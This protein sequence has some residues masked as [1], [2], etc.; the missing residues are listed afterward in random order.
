ML[1][2]VYNDTLTA[3]ASAASTIYGSPGNDTI[4]AGTS[5]T[6]DYSTLNIYAAAIA[7]SVSGG[8][9]TVDKTDFLG[10]DTITL[11]NTAIVGTNGNDSFTGFY[12]L[13]DLT[14][15]GLAGSDTYT[16][17]MTQFGASAGDAGVTIVEDSSGAF[18]NI[19]VSNADGSFIISIDSN[20]FYAAPGI[21]EV[22]MGYYKWNSLADY[23][24]VLDVTFEKQQ[25]SSEVQFFTIGSTN[26]E[27]GSWYNDVITGATGNHTIDG[28][29]GTN[30]ID[31]S[32]APAGITVDLATNTASNGWGYTDAL[33]NIQ[34][35]IGSSHNDTITGDSNDN[36]IS[37][38][39]GNN[40]LDGGSGT[41]TLDYSSDPAGVTVDLATGTATNGWSG[42]DTISNFQNVIGS[43][44][45]DVITG[46]SNN[47]VI[48]GG[49]GNNTLDGGGG[50]NTLDYSH[51]PAGVTVDLVTGT[52]T[53]GYGGTDTI[54]NFQNVLGSN[55]G[56]TIIGNGNNVI[57]CGSGND[58][59]VDGGGNNTFD[60]GGGI[61][62]LDYSNDPAGV[63][64]D[65]ATGT[66]TNGFG[67]TDTITN[68]QNVI[69]SA[70]GD[71]ITG[72]AN[73]NVITVG[74]GNNTLD[75]GG[76]TNTLDYSHQTAGVYVDLV[77]GW[78]TNGSGGTDTISNFQDVIGSNY[79]DTIIGDGNNVITGGSGNDHVIDGG[80]NNVFDGGGGT[81]TLD[82]S[83]DPAAVTVDLSAGTASNGFGGTDTISNFQN[84]IGSAYDDVIT[85]DSNNNVID[86]A[87]GNNTLD[88]GGGTNTLDYHNDPSSVYVD[89]PDGVVYNGYGG[90]DTITN[91]QN[92]ISSVYGDTILG[93]S[94]DNVIT[95]M[96]ANNYVDGGGGTNTID[97]SHATS[98]VTIDL[99]MYVA[100]NDGFGG[101]DDLYNIQNIIG[102]N[103]GDLITGNGNNVITCGSGD[104]YVID[105]GGNNVF[106]G[107]GGTN[108]LSYEADPAGVTVDLAT[109]TATN[110]FSGTD[111]ISNFQNVVGSYYDDVIT[112]DSHNNI[113]D[114]GGGNN[115]LD[116]GGGI[117]TLDYSHDPG[118]V[119][120]ELSSGI[121][122]N[123]YGGTDTISN[124][125]N[126]I[127]SASNDDIFGD[128]NNNVISG[129]AG[130]NTLDGGGGTNTLDYSHN[131]GSVYVDLVDGWATNGWA[132]TDTISNFQNV[133]GSNF[134]DTI[135]GNGNNVITCGSGDDYVIDGGGN[136]TF[137]GGGGTN[138]L[139]YESDP[140][141]VTVD[142]SA[143]TATNGFGGTD[144]ISNFQVVV[145]S[146][147][148]DSITGDGSTTVSYA[149]ATG[150][151]TVDLSAGTATGDGSDTLSG[152][153]GVIGSSYDDTITCDN[154]NDVIYGNGG[155]D[156]I[157]CGSGAD[158][159]L[160][161]GA[162]ALTGVDTINNFN[163]SNG[164]KIDIADVISTYDPL[165]MLISNFVELTTSGSNTQVKVDTDGSGSSYTQIATIEGV[166]GLSLATLIS[167]GNLIVHHT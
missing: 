58:H 85:G 30:T 46:D 126:V 29:P 7:V 41:N 63:T 10:E 24:N 118:S 158:T 164:D 60:G 119:I 88:G 62:T 59:V 84:V 108:T 56:D 82:Y 113:I 96:G 43:A 55:Y 53:N 144:T 31:Y 79:G 17:D 48:D 4:T 28:G 140:A 160:F 78:A 91:F 132:G 80:G 137:N 5:T 16:F 155:N 12:V 116:G 154:N 61:N 106:D 167:D 142:L 150:A 159:I 111:T 37:G 47:N 64:V 86:G 35:V 75:G 139:S 153:T 27:F 114:G 66:A 157:Y 127:G 104:D 70:Y 98:G 136:N 120:V 151:V 11:S 26:Y 110:G 39:A 83:N 165:S 163:T 33:Y 49:A 92:I 93:D 124:F 68:F 152:I 102:S 105:G 8:V 103:F 18:S 52:A 156:A 115:T 131:P 100:T 138:T 166:T 135:I 162:T 128:L 44:H 77:D 69:G 32:A 123:G 36:L 121:A 129:G 122:Y 65:L 51:D 141:G 1:G 45:D 20:I 95:I 76:G 148:D 107:G 3:L 42:T 22:E 112:G 73:D 87:G 40:T 25:L 130:D 125:Q 13:H 133:L 94:N 21:F 81:N 101:T 117:N 89:M 50:T 67:G 6:V 19:S 15:E 14:F 74:G 109:G 146:H 161:K 38:G 9:A 34:N 97:Y 2:S 149:S 147:Y 72:D 54:S 99:T 90:T 71:V 57:T 134:G 145:G 23:N 143:G